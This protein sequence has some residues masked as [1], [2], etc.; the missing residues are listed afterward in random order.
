[1]ISDLAQIMP[2]LQILTMQF[3]KLKLIWSPGAHYTAEIFH[4]SYNSI[5]ILLVEI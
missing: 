2:K 1:M 3:P 4:V 5:L